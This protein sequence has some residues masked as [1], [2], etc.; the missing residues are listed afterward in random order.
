[1]L[2]LVRENTTVGLQV[3]HLTKSGRDGNFCAS[4]VAT[5]CCLQIVGV[6]SRVK[7]PLPSGHFQA[8]SS[9]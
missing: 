9:G 8:F 3:G 7:P 5:A 1:M 6:E 2:L 4:N